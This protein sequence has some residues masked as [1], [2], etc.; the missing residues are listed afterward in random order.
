MGYANLALRFLLE[1]AGVAAVAWWGYQ[2][3]GDGALRIVLA[4]AV[5]AVFV[6][7]WW[8][9]VAPRAVNPI[10]Q[11]MRVLIGTALLLVAAVGLWTADQALLAAIY[12]ALVLG[13]AALMP[14]LGLQPHDTVG[15]SRTGEE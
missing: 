11:P 3:S 8:R 7:A 13:N 12:A 14:V 4:I 1:L 9:V 6:L 15:G 2:L 10:A 5:P